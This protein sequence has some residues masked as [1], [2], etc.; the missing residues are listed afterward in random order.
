MGFFD[1]A[2]SPAFGLGFN[3]LTSIL[4]NQRNQ[5][6]TEQREFLF[7]QGQ[8]VSG[9]KEFPGI[10]PV[11]IPSFLQPQDLLGRSRRLGD[12]L[13]GK[14]QVISDAQQSRLQGAFGPGSKFQRQL[15]AIPGGFG[16][17][18]RGILD[19]FGT[20]AGNITDEFQQGA[21]G[22]LGGFGASGD[23]LRN[24]F[25][26]G[27]GGINQGFQNRL[28]EA[29]GILEGRGAQ[30]EEDIS[31]RFG[32]SLSVQQ[33]DLA[34]RGLG[35][36]TIQANISAGNVERESAEQRRLQEQLRGE[37]LGLFTDLSGEALDAQGRLLG[38]GTNL[39]QSLLGAGTT[40]GQNL[41]GAG[42]NLQ[43]GFAGQQFA[44]AQ[45]ANQFGANLSLNTLG[46]QSGLAQFLAQMLGLN[47]QQSLS[48]QFDFGQSTLGLQER[49]Q[50]RTSGNLGGCDIL[51][52][53]PL[54]FSPI[55]A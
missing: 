21:Q 42:T 39:G 17:A 29:L 12:Q 31:R 37:R 35:S 20:A 47:Q 13:A 9:L 36:T 15:G 11:D 30:A 33:T 34:R 10:P 2:G 41:L 48:N 55:L 8:A 22:L 1:F 43:A 7:A 44:G 53:Q 52:P 49:L 24:Q 19:E 32:E 3:F 16:T 46:A 6:T 38:A 25:A 45:G 14:S 54:Q 50:N 51:N 26:Q 40:L 27:A 4:E 28:T 23:L 18:S 5:L